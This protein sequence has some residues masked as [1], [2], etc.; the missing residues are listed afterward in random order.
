MSAAKEFEGEERDKFFS[1]MYRVYNAILV[2]GCAGIIWI[3]KI[4]AALMYQK[5]FFE[6]WILVPPLLISVIFGALEGFLGSICL[7]FK[8]GQSI[9][10]ATG[11][12]AVVNIVLNYIFIVEFGTMGAAI[13]TLVS[14]FVMFALALIMVRKYVKLRIHLFRDVVAYLLLVAEAL[15]VIM[16]MK[17]YFWI[18][19]GIVIVLAAMY[20][21]ELGEMVKKCLKR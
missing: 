20:C 5:E 8:D 16:N 1:N 9:G 17:N 21:G 7:A 14:Y 2:V 3:L 13:A 19:A 11:A 12:G 4:L 18:N 15:L 6:A 10:K